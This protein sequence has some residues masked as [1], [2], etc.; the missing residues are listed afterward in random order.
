MKKTVKYTY[1]DNGDPNCKERKDFENHL[2]QLYRICVRIQTNIKVCEVLEESNADSL[3]LIAPNFFNLAFYN[4]YAMIAIDLYVLFDKGK[5]SVGLKKFI[6]TTLQ[7]HKSI[8]TKTFYKENLNVANSKKEI[9]KHSIIDVCNDLKSL[10]NENKQLIESLKY[11]RD[12]FYAHCDK[13]V[14]RSEIQYKCSLTEFKNLLG[15][16]YKIIN[17]IGVLYDSIERSF[18]AIN[19][20]DIKIL[21]DILNSCSNIPNMNF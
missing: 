6:D 18:D 14:L 9:Q 13:Q 3:F 19:W 16:S 4:N 20:D 21:I 1:I 7:N 17:R 12:K 8:F 10:L 15:L 11:D 5:D 2:E